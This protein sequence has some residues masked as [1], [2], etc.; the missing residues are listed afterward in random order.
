MST[1]TITIPGLQIAYRSWGDPQNP[2]I[3]AM[4]GWLDNANSFEQLANE[5]AQNY[6]F[7]AIDLPGHG[8]SSHLPPGSNYHFTDGIFTVVEIINAFQLDKVH[9]L[10]HSMGACLASLIAGVAP[11]RL[12]SLSLIEGL[13][14]F[15]HP[16]D[17]ACS[18]L[19]SYMK[20]VSTKKNKKSKGYPSFADA[21]KARAASGYVSLEIATKLCERGV[22]EEETLFHWRHDKRLIAPSPLRMTEGQIL[23]CLKTI[24]A[25][26]ILFWA[27]NGFSFD[28]ELMQER[29]KTVNNLKV[30]QLNGGHH[31]HMEQPEVIAKLL[32]DFYLTI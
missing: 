9:I 25:P 3:L 20:F 2:P 8:H 4:H 16:E 26:S 13:G 12:L 21:C 28:S 27:S 19:T 5:L 24:T 15:S 10:G 23:S 30:E 1:L 17:S 11:E 31:I 32:A 7:I 6:Y 18:Q 14:P 22:V 29:I